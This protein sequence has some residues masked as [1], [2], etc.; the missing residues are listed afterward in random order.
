[1]SI[2]FINR[3]SI[4]PCWV[5]R[6]RLLR[7][8]RHFRYLGQY[9]RPHEVVS[10]IRSSERIGKWAFII[11]HFL[12]R[13]A[14][15]FYWSIGVV[16]HYGLRACSRFTA[17]L[18]TTQPHFVAKPPLSFPRK[19]PKIGTNPKCLRQTSTFLKILIVIL[20]ISKNLAYYTMGINRE[21]LP[22]V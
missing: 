1:M 2:A 17:H 13:I 8:P 10:H 16:T 3:P 20:R 18:S 4:P 22:F 21:R 12:R 7:L 15:L 6:R 9:R 14:S 11:G 19:W 5:T